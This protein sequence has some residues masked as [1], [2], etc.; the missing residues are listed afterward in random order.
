[1]QIKKILIGTDLYVSY[2]LLPCINRGSRPEV[3]CKKC[4]LKQFANFNISTFTGKYLCHS[5]LLNEVAGLRRNFKEQLFFIKHLQWLLLYQQSNS[6]KSTVTFYLLD[7]GHK[8]NINKICRRSIYV[9]SP[10]DGYIGTTLGNRGHRTPHSPNQDV[11]KREMKLCPSWVKEYF[12][13]NLK[14]CYQRLCWITNFERLLTI[15]MM[16]H[17]MSILKNIS[18][19]LRPGLTDPTF[20]FFL[21]T[22]QSLS[23]I[24]SCFQ[25]FHQDYFCII[26]MCFPGLH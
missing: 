25:R 14:I 23:L 12:W 2:E 13:K 21:S 17:H 20:Y 22:Y 10:G 11:E 8:L 3:F 26:I 4:V 19:L 16:V 15:S 18:T 6:E 1:M 5:L 24:L 9:L 7:K